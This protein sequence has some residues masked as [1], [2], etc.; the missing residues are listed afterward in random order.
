LFTLAQPRIFSMRPRAHCLGL[1]ADLR[2]ALASQR[3]RRRDAE[4]DR[5]GW[6]ETV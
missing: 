6:A 1:Q 2:F 4:Y 3:Q 5:P